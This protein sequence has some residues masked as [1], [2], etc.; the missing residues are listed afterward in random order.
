[1][2]ELTV[3]L[4]A[5]GMS[6]LHRAGTAGLYMTVQAMKERGVRP[7]GLE[8]WDVTSRSVTLRWSGTAQAFF[9]DLAHRTFGIADDGMV[10]FIAIDRTKASLA[11]RWIVHEGMFGTF[12]QFG[13]NNALGEKQS[14]LESADGDGPP[15][16]Y[17]YKP[18]L[19]GGAKSYP[20]RD[21]GGREIGAAVDAARTVG[22]TSWLYP[23]AMV[24]HSGLGE[25]TALDEE[26]SRALALLFAPVGCFFFKLQSRQHPRKARA[27]I[28]VPEIDDLEA[29]GEARRDFGADLKTGEVIATGA[30]H[31][32]LQLLTRL[33]ARDLLGR[34]GL[35]RVSVTIFGIVTWNEKQKSR[36]A[37]VE[38]ERRRERDLQAF[39]RI[40]QS[41]PLRVVEKKDGGTFASV[42]PCMELFANNVAV[43]REF[44]SGF[45]EL[46]T[47]KEVR[48]A[49]GADR[50]G[51]SAMVSREAKVIEESSQQAF[52]EACHEA[53]R[54]NYG[55]V[56]DR[57]KGEGVDAKARLEKEYDR[58]RY[59]FVRSKNLAAFREAV[60]DFWSRGG[61]K[62]TLKEEWRSVLPFLSEER[63]RQGRDLALLALASYSRPETTG[64][65]GQGSQE[66]QE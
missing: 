65:E 41:F 62:K 20:H 39:Q 23:G 30:G 6:A 61:G 8:S 60:A 26:P 43:G 42:S 63:W 32:A 29:Y 47:N 24:R 46:M 56:G 36:T 50:K 13:P 5:P 10:D 33:S 58:W 40:R 66:G 37:H 35:P 17:E 19:R 52:I 31:A 9:D 22:L 45:A 64:Q 48:P 16:H 57:A 53:L 27:A 34:L 49:L 7:A 15:L 4:F 54:C 25:A 55:I 44:H 12:C 1:M 3:D 2:T 28:A 38:V 51:L 14:L 21:R 59:A 18:V 11:A